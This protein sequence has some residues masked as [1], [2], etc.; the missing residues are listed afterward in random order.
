MTTK[1]EDILLFYALTPGY[2]HEEK[3]AIYNALEDFLNRKKVLDPSD[4]FNIVIFHEDGPNYLE[5]FTLNP[6]NI[7]LALKTL[8][9]MISKAN[10]SGG[11][12]VSVTFIIDVFKKIPDK[13]FRIIILSIFNCL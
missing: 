7:M 3:N 12:M 2:N 4:R 9:P 10:M 8:E 1:S 13:C 6:E 5:D 11:I